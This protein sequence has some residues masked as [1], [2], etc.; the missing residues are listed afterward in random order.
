MDLQ[1]L[2]RTAKCK[3]KRTEGGKEKNK[4]IKDGHRK[5]MQEAD[6][7]FHKENISIA[8]ATIIIIIIIKSAHQQAVQLYERAKTNRQTIN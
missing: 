8:T 4:T 1:H 5:S 7:A 6:S 2:I 3:N